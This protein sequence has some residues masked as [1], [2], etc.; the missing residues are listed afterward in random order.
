MTNYHE[1]IVSSDDKFFLNDSA[2]NFR[3][4]LPT[5]VRFNKFRV[6]S[7]IVPFTY[8]V[9]NSTNN[10]LVASWNDGAGS[11]NIT[12]PEGTYT[13]SEFVAM[14]N[15]ISI[16]GGITLALSFVETTGKFK[17][18]LS[19]ASFTNFRL[20]TVLRDDLKDVMGFLDGEYVA[21]TGGVYDFAYPAQLSGPN[22]LCIRSNY[23]GG[24]LVP[25]SYTTSAYNKQ[26]NNIISKINVNA[27][28]GEVIL[29][30][31]DLGIYNFFNTQQESFL[32]I[33]DFQLTNPDG[34]LVP[35]PANAEWSMRCAFYL[36]DAL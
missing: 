3:V 30:E 13:S 22:Y 33:V 23:L 4:Q 34:S 5:N 18:T 19:G 27:N 11:A 12:L 25:K 35:L 26:Q 31:R 16:G 36:D 15:A 32:N 20:E 8:Y 17:L 10:Q 7:A 1:I 6:Q 9:I 14:W 2:N 21:V 28:F 24:C 29:Q